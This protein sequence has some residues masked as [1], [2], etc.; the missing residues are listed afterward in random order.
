[1]RLSIVYN[2][3]LLGTSLV[4]AVPAKPRAVGD[5]VPVDMIGMVNKYKTHIDTAL[6]K[7]D[8]N[9]SNKVC[10]HSTV[11]VRKEW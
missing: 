3:A 9:K 7:K 8:K 10:K 1:M 2:A 4:S 6:T 11:T 5:L